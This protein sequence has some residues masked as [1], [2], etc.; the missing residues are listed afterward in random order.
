MA[1]PSDHTEA[2]CWGCY[3]QYNGGLCVDAS[4]TL[5][6]PQH[7]GDCI[8]GIPSYLPCSSQGTACC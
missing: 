5:S 4:S 2:F 1:M 7:F 8:D 6:G 3:M